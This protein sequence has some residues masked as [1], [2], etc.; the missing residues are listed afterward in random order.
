M[1]SDLT[2]DVLPKK[3]IVM[4][5]FFPNFGLRNFTTIPVKNEYEFDKRK[6]TGPEAIIHRSFQTGVDGV[7]VWFGIIIHPIFSSVL[8]LIP[9]LFPILGSR[10][11]AD[12]VVMPGTQG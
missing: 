6:R 7:C 3:L 8:G 9:I 4:V 12:R 11:V 5:I 2:V 10:P 1:R